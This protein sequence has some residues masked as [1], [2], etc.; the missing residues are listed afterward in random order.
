MAEQACS[1]KKKSRAAGPPTAIIRSENRGACRASG[2]GGVTSS[3]HHARNRQQLLP[4]SEPTR[5]ARDLLTSSTSA[6]DGCSAADH[7]G[8]DHGI[9]HRHRACCARCWRGV[10]VHAGRGLQRHGRA[11]RVPPLLGHRRCGSGPVLRAVRQQHRVRRRCARDQPGRRLHAQAARCGAPGGPPLCIVM[12]HCSCLCPIV[13]DGGG[14]GTEFDSSAW[15]AGTTCAKVSTPR[16]SCA[17]PGKPG[18]PIGPGPPP[19]PPPSPRPKPPPG[20]PPLVPKWPPTFNM[21]EV[22]CPTTQP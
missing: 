1:S 13:A 19:G 7:H 4:A 22:C 12:C 11:P 15:G 18:V 17:P 6:S 5:A 21:S 9:D 16:L 14:R 8:I 10:Q 3:D 2:G 20:P